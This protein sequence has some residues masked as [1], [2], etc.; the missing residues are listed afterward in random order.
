[1]INFNDVIKCNCDL[2]EGIKIKNESIAWVD[3]NKDEIFLHRDSKLNTFKTQYKPSLI[4]NIGKHE[5]IYGSDVG[6]CCLNLNSGDDHMLNS[7]SFNHS[8]KKYRSNDG[9]FCGNHQLLSFMHRND[10]VNNSGF[11]YIIYEGSS[12]LLD[13]GLHIPNS[14]I[15]IE[16]FKILI[17][18]SLKG[19]IWLYHLD[20]VGK[21]I[22]K[23]L[24][25]QLDC[26][27]SPDG[28]CMVGD[29]I[30]V[31]L[32]DGA[33]IAVFDKSGKLLRELSLPIIRP[34][35]CKFDKVRSQLWIT[36]ASEGLSVEQ[37]N[38]YPL[39][40]NTFIYDLELQSLC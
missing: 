8:Y 9:G 14:F 39:S 6:I 19:K 12:I 22:K 3:I 35:N 26:G 17:S 13:D 23:D 34:T 37:K 2:G 30:F 40:G 25:A 27:L 24:W 16:P 31:A 7:I 1:M 18:D 11:L 15:E 5:L 33:C 20:E 36:S 29:Y 28:G 4:Y 38:I 10:P 32:W 21:I